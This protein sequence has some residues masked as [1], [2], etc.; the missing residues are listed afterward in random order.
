MLQLSSWFQIFA[1][2][3]NLMFNVFKKSSIMKQGNSFK[4]IMIASIIL[5]QFQFAYIG[6]IL[7][8]WKF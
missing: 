2:K 1:F 7:V 6:S 5:G 8:H 4:A 3:I